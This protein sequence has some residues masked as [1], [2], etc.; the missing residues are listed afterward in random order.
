[1]KLL[2]KEQQETSGKAILCY[3]C[4]KRFEDKFVQ[5]KKHSKVGDQCHYIGEYRAPVHSISSL[6]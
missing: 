4:T 5:Y 3:I 6:T 2:I 1:M